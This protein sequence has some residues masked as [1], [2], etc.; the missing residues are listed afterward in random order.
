[1]L[2]PWEVALLGGVVLLWRPGF[3]VSYI[4]SSLTSVKRSPL[5]CLKI[6]M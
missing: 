2:G 6:K 3:E 1:M 5:G 4:S